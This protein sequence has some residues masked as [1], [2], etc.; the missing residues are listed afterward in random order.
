MSRNSF[1]EFK[2]FRINQ[3]N[4]A[5]KVGTDGVLL[6]AWTPIP[7]TATHILDIG[8]GSG[9]LALMVAQRTHSHA[10]ID[11]VEIDPTAAQQAK[12]NFMMSP[13]T[14]QLHVI[15]SDFQSFEKNTLQ[16]YDVI[17]SNPPYFRN[18]LQTPNTERTMARHSSTLSLDDL[19]AGVT[20]LLQPWGT[21]SVILPLVEGELLREKA[22]KM[23]LFCTHRTFVSPTPTSPAKRVLLLFSFH[24]TEEEIHHLTIE[25]EKRHHYTDA[26]K[27]LTQA[28]YLHF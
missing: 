20:R 28:Y 17:L 4:C 24:Q 13:W 11:A 25:T 6:G 14:Q 18:S 16:K 7:P 1:F 5:M 27:N 21:F 2:Q 9:L 8:T 12:E 3:E 22:Y 23:G 19:V 15:H 26:Y 10:H